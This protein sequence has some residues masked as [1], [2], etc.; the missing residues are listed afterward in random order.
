MKVVI[1]TPRPLFRR[2]LRKAPAHPL[3]AR[4]LVREFPV[5][6]KSE[7]GIDT[8][9]IAKE[10]YFA[11]TLIAVGDQ[12]ADR[13]YDLGVEMGDEV[14]YGKYAGLV[15]E[16]Q[17]IVGEDKLA[18]PHDGAWEFVP[19]TDKAWELVGTPNEN[20]RLRRCR[21]CETLKLT[22]RVIVLSVDDICLDVDLELRLESGEMVRRRGKDDEG[23]TRYYIERAWPEDE[24]VDEYET[25]TEEAA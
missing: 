22:E 24:Q 11:G 9:D 14:W 13:L 20:M 6:S 3:G 15:Q 21:S 25:K 18:C 4:V 12:A 7:G 1:S 23:R 19:A 10:R 16:W 17:H 8:P 5:E 2:H